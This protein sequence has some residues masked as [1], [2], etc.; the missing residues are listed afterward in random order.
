VSI[1]HVFIDFKRACSNVKRNKVIRLM[2][3]FDINPG[4]QRL[5]EE[6]AK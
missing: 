5:D 3:E 1:F 2:E 6:I 4:D